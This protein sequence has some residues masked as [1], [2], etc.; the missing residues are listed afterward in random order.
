M[1]A[2][3]R[4]R[5]LFAATG[6][7]IGSHDGVVGSQ[8]VQSLIADIPEIALSADVEGIDICRVFSHAMTPALMNALAHAIDR[9]VQSGVAGVVVTHGTDTLEET[10]YA[11]ALQL[12]PTVPIVLTGAMRARGARGNDGLANLV[13]ATRVALTPETARFGPVVVM[14]DE[15]HLARWV[16]KVHTARL[17]AIASPEIGPVG[18]IV[19]GE[20]RLNVAPGASEFMGLPD[21]LSHR[22]EVILA[23]AGADGSLVDAARTWADGIVVAGTGGG[24]VPPDMAR[25]L[26]DATSAGF[27]VVLASRTGAGPLLRGTYRGPGS[28]A[29]LRE[30][31]VIPAHSL[32]AVKARLRLMVALALGI[33][34]RAAFEAT[35]RAR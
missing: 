26:R 18:S 25:A 30:L 16:T 21:R 3:E 35:G 32:S 4:P 23:V 7:T 8:G 5:L 24:H 2:K 6:G 34:P 29:E 14:Q 17:A 11:L 31:G 9:A 28:D 12:R 15:I 19:E 22:V 27:P 33:G 13:A 10:A 20:V 1:V